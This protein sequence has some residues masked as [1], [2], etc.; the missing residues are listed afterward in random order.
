M[1]LMY[2]FNYRI[3]SLAD[4]LEPHCESLMKIFC[5]ISRNMTDPLMDKFGQPT[6]PVVLTPEMSHKALTYTVYIEILCSDDALDKLRSVISH[7]LVEVS[8]EGT[9]LDIE[10]LE[11]DCSMTFL[12]ALVNEIQALS[13]IRGDGLPLPSIYEFS[14]FTLSES[15]KTAID[16][17]EE[18]FEAD[19]V[20][21]DPPMPIDGAEDYS[22][23]GTAYLYGDVNTP[24]V[25][26]D[27]DGVPILIGTYQYEAE[28]VDGSQAGKFEWVVTRI[29]MIPRMP[30]LEVLAHCLN[31]HPMQ[32]G[33]GDGQYSY[34]SPLLLI[35]DVESMKY[36]LQLGTLLSGFIDGNGV[37]F[38]DH[39][40]LEDELLVEVPMNDL[41]MYLLSI[42]ELYDFVGYFNT[43][44]LKE[45]IKGFTA[46]TDSYDKDK[47]IRH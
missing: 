43:D 14:H 28:N 45:H 11:D 35:S 10:P 32:A 27:D 6:S 38:F 18:S 34:V 41:Y 17:F 23:R 7:L 16:I 25:L 26:V 47:V 30:N 31:T 19:M 2:D 12:T 29:I 13:E 33:F 24:S 40:L 21:F 46:S 36:L 3:Q 44:T 20:I 8:A 39:Y 4:E 15:N 37:T 42:D 1:F 9:G 22:A 5:D